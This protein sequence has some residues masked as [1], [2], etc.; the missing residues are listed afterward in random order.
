MI[1]IGIT[2]SI[3]M[4][5]TTISTMLTLLNIP[6]HDSD[7]NVRILL[8]SNLNVINHIK[9]KW[10][11]CFHYPE[12][13]NLIDKDKLSGIIF[14]DKSQKKILEN[15]IH[16]HVLKSRDIFLKK[17]LKQNNR[18]VGLDVPLLFETDVDR[19][20]N[21]VFLAYASKKT[22]RKRVLKRKNMT[23]EKFENILNNQ[24]SDL[25]K[26]KKNPILIMTDFGKII[27][28]ML[29]IINL[30]KIIFMEK[31]KK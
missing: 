21:Y 18:I 3:G 27:T 22:Q 29:L 25:D 23:V 7:E 28:F 4:G 26:K 6:I 5:K 15:I 9:K 30:V 14:K 1:I 2:G 24:M 31:M 13:E 17:C 10:P 12:S 8:A 16:P 20:C 11:Y 19:I